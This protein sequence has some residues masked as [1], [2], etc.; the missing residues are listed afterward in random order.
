MRQNSICKTLGFYYPSLKRRLFINYRDSLHKKQSIR[1]KNILLEAPPFLNEFFIGIADT[2]T[3]LTKINYAYDLRNFFRYITTIDEFSHLSPDLFTLKD[4]DNITTTHIE[5]FLHY[6]SSYEKIY[7]TPLN[8]KT[9]INRQ[10][11]ER[12]KSRKLSSIRVMYSYFLKKQKVSQNPALIVETPKLREKAITYL[13]ADETAR[14]IDTVEQG[15]SLTTSQ[16]VYHKYTKNRD[17]A[18]V[19]LLLGTGI[20]L[21]ECIGININHIDF[22]THTIKITRKGGNEAI[23]YFGDEVAEALLDYMEERK[24]ATP[25][26]NHEQALFL[27][28]QNKR[29]TERAVQNLVK[30]YSGIVSVKNISPHKLRSTYGTS[31]YKETGDIYI[32]AAALGHKDVNTTKKHY[33]HIDEESLRA[34]SKKIKLRKG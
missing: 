26:P 27:S 6:T 10:N 3:L 21:N 33:A 1:L 29:I 14:L 4:L 30:K 11:K 17:V 16:K 8:K 5:N 2:K 20:R 23:I 12:G 9:T 13:Q 22:K 28:M 34:S 15:N 7:K 24:K 31:L 25:A 18:I 19:S 32:V